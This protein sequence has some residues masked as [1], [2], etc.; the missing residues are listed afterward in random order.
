VSRRVLALNVLLGL[1]GA[2]CAAGL[3]RE[4]LSPLPLPP[5]PAPRAA[6]PAAAA[7]PAPPPAGTARAYGIV[8]SRSLFSPSRSEAPAGPVLAAGPK[9]LLH[10]VVMDGPKSRAYLEDLLLKRTFGYTVGDPISG[11]RLQSI[12]RDRVVIARPEGL[13]EV[14][15]QDPAKPRTVIP[16]AAAGATLP[17]PAVPTSRLPAAPSVPPRANER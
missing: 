9:P 3:I 15:L 4:V 11:G 8:A 10:G 7:V 6:A 17:A 14:F 16:A 13:I 1:L 2:L 12:T 5:P